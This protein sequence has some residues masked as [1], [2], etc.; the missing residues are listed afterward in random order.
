MGTQ[1]NCFFLSINTVTI[2]VEALGE[3]DRRL[4]KLKIFI[5]FIQDE[6]IVH[7]E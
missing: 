3:I 7:L 4:N 2:Q 1:Y 6:L 5:K